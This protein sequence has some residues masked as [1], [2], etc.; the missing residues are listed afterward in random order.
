MRSLLLFAIALLSAFPAHADT[1]NFAVTGADGNFSFSLPTAATPLSVS[2]YFGEYSLANA[3]FNGHVVSGDIVIF[4]A[5][6]DNGGLYLG[7]S[8]GLFS[9]NEF[10]PQIF[11]SGNTGPV[12]HD[13]TFT[14]EGGAALTDGMPST[15]SSDLLKVSVDPASANVPEL[16]SFV[17][18]ATGTTGLL[19]PSRRQHR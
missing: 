1:V 16:S 12:F 14:F 19:W 2:P 13:G 7:S 8:N 15:A 6:A 3:S 18:L 5:A 9:L 11:A 10:G 17:L 4:Y